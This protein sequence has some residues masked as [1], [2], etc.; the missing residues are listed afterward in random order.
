MKLKKDNQMNKRHLYYVLDNGYGEGGVMGL[1]DC[2]EWIKG[3][4]EANFPDAKNMPEDE[5][6]NYTL[7]PIW[8]T[9]ED[10]EA[11]PDQ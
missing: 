3:D 10:Y 7:T 11:L 6:P 9:D 2:M 1:S 8:Y 5:L 4:M